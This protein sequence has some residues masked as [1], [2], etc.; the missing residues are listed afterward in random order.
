MQALHF[1]GK[2]SEYFKIWIVNILLIIITFGIYYPWAKVRTQRYFHANTVLANRNFEYHATG[3]QLFISY[4]IA[5][6]LLIIY[7]VI[8]QISPIGAGIVL[9]MLFAAYPWIIWRS[10]KFRMRMTSFSNVRFSFDG[11]LKSAYFNFMLL[12][13]LLIL[14]IYIIPIA[15][16]VV[17]PTMSADPSSSVGPIMALGIIFSLAMAFY[18][19][20]VMQQR[21]NTYII[22]GCRYG[23]GQFDTQLE[24]REFAKILAKTIGLS[25]FLTV[26]VIVIVAV[27]TGLTI[28]LRGGQEIIQQLND[29]ATMG[30]IISQLLI[31]IGP[32]Y[33]L[34]IVSGVFI[35]AYFRARI[36]AYVFANA[37]LDENIM[38]YSTLGAR[39]LTWVIVSNFF[40]IVLTA[41]L[42]T[43]WAQVRMSRTIIENTQVDTNDS[44]DS[45]ISQQQEQ[46]S[47]LGE[48]LG[49][50][51]DVDVAVGL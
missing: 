12:P 21:N 39:R 44:I 11:A 34:L 49:D 38:F 16:A 10:L 29:P 7:I 9:L 4:L 24:S 2:G 50:A 6:V 17:L 45:Y 35:A 14:S 5:M 43:P 47:A 15:L 19:V 28:G 8:Q 27:L 3:K 25:I 33:L 51:F 31:V 42:A 36:R 23:Q 37:Y 32:L 46:Q 26:L 1:E 22:S 40:I 13:F 41:G 20:A 30:L 48:Q 18:I